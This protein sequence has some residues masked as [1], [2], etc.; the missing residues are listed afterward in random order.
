MAASKAQSSTAN[1]TPLTANFFPGPNDVI[2]ARG[3]EA[4]NHVGNQGYKA[5]IKR[6]LDKYA[7]ATSKYEKTIMVSRIIECIRS[8]SPDGGFV[9]QED[10][11]WYEV[12]DHLARE[13]VGQ[14]LRDSLHSLYKSSTKAKRRRREVFSAGIVDN[15]ATLIQSSKAVS[16]RIRQLSHDMKERGEAAS[17]LFVF[18]MFTQANF[19]ILE[20][21]KKDRSL[22]KKF[23]EAEAQQKGFLCA[24][25]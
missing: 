12:G 25:V 24:A 8:S 14:S 5:I 16:I 4:K 21:F 11:V 22:L 20:A 2:C 7:Q 17:E 19:D 6:V 23:N 1:M 9:K 10:Y 3:K 13:K 15:V 18:H